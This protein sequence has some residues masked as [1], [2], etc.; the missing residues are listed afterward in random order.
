MGLFGK[1]GLQGLPTR[2]ALPLR[3]IQ[4]RLSQWGY[5]GPPIYNMGLSGCSSLVR[6]GSQCLE[7][8]RAGDDLGN[9][10]V[11]VWVAGMLA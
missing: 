3:D 7:T 11:P 6:G 8:I 10:D 1:C 9:S 4:L 5:L 2:V